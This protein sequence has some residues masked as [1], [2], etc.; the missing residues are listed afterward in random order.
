MSLYHFLRARLQTPGSV[1]VVAMPPRSGKTT[2]VKKLA[3]DWKD[4]QLALVASSHALAK[5]RGPE[6]IGAGQ[7][8]GGRGYDAIIIDDCVK[9]REDAESE[10]AMETLFGWFGENLAAHRMPGASMLIV[11]TRFGPKDFHARVVASPFDL[12]EVQVKE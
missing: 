8:M 9:C 6:W 7:P 1:T 3:E 10:V 12:V 4:K 5:A 11:G 2:L